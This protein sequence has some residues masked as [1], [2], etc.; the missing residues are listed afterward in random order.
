MESKF[1]RFGGVKVEHEDGS[2]ITSWQTMTDFLGA[3]TS[4]KDAL[5][6]LC[7]LN[8]IDKCIVHF[9]RRNGTM[10]GKPTFRTIENHV[11]TLP[12]QAHNYANQANETKIKVGLNGVNVQ[13]PQPQQPQQNF[14]YMMQP[15]G[16]PLN[17]VDPNVGSL[18]GAMNNPNGM[19]GLLQQTVVAAQNELKLEKEKNK[20]LESQIRQLERDKEKAEFKEQMQAEINE[21]KNSSGLNTKEI[22]AGIKDFLPGIAKGFTGQTESGEV[23][24][25]G[26]SIDPTKLTEN[27]R[28]IIATIASS[29][30]S[31]NQLKR[32]T[33]LISAY[34]AL[35]I[36][37]LKEFAVEFDKI[38]EKHQLL[39]SDITASAVEEEF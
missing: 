2:K 21:L 27:Q 29:K 1:R 25:G 15:N 4:Y 26:V 14:N 36:E 30:Y 38:L 13:E 3:N 11:F 31:E 8:A 18:A 16:N 7:E 12:Q 10:Y 34:S 22:L 35:S 5:I 20:M 33:A 28:V 9:G 6:E 24:L 37:E 23:N 17:Y 19:I 39:E 32:I